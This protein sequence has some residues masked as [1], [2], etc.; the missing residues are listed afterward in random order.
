MDITLETETDTSELD[1]ELAKQQ[2]SFTGFA[3]QLW[4]Y[5]T[6]KQLLGDR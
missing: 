6:I 4:A 2:H 1:M 5:L 3:R